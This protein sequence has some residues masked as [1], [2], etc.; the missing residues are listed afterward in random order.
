MLG[1]GELHLTGGEDHSGPPNPKTHAA[2]DQMQAELVRRVNES[3]GAMVVTMTLDQEKGEVHYAVG[4]ITPALP[5]DQILHFLKGCL[6]SGQH[7]AGIVAQRAANLFI[8]QV[9]DPEAG[10]DEVERL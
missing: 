2:R 7:S 8:E 5:A 6:E 10:G 4:W 9:N 3:D 1:D